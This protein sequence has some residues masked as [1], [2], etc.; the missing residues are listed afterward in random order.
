MVV[1][2][3][4][5][6]FGQVQLIGLWQCFFECLVVQVLFIYDDLCNCCCYFNVCVIF[7]E[8]LCLGVLFV[9]NEN[10]IVLVD[11]FKLGD[12]DNFVVIVV[13]LIDVDVLFIVIDIDGLYSVD[14]CCDLQVYLIYDVFELILQVLV[15]VGGVGSGVGIGGMYIKLEVVVK[16]GCVGI[17]ICLFN[18]CDS[19]VVC[20][21]V[22]GWLFGM[23]I[24]VGQIWVVVC[25]YWLCYVLLE[26]GVILVDDGVVVVL[27][28]K[29]VLLL[30]GGVFGVEGDFCCGDMVEVW[31]C[32]GIGELCLVCGVSQY[33]VSDICC[34]VGYYLC[35]IECV[36]GYNYGGN[37]IYCDDLV[38]L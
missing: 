13:V 19:D 20:V 35:D 21:L 2:Q 24:Y 18:G 17:E 1:C 28:D 8:L 31:L 12:N 9:V 26:L 38:L 10:D 25:K 32:I 23:C 30:F 6:V 16:V 29:G 5:V 4:L 36:L 7:N 11:E 3:V 22:Q 27:C 34:V 37:V 33:L 15:M 14:L